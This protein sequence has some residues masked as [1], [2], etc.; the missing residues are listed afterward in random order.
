MKRGRINSRFKIRANTPATT[1]RTG[2]DHASA[3]YA[4][5]V[6]REFEYIS[7][8]SHLNFEFDSALAYLHAQRA[9]GDSRFFLLSGRATAKAGQ[10]AKGENA[11][12]A[13]REEER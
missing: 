1:A 9:I 10:S 2:G 8:R 13:E 5:H 11:K 4:Q 7:M 6:R 3:R 12:R